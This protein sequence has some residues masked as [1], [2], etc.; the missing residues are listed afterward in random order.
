MDHRYH[1]YAEQLDALKRASRHR[2]FKTIRREGDYIRYHNHQML[3]LSSND[4]LGI[5]QNQALQQQFLHENSNHTA[6][7]SSS[8]SRLLTGHFEQTEQLEDSLNRAFGRQSLVF[9]SGYHMNIG[10]LPALTAADSLIISDELIHASIIDGIRLSKA[11]RQR[12]AHQDFI[13][14]EQLLI[15]AQQRDDIRHIF[16]VTESLFSMDGDITDLHALVTLRNRYPKVL[17]YVDD[18]HGVGVYGERGLGCAEQH[19]V[20]A[21]IDILVGT[22]GKA[23]ASQGGY[24]ICDGVIR[25]YLINTVRPLI[26]STALP[27]LNLAWTQFVFEYMQGQC[28]AR[29]HLAALSQQLIAAIHARGLQCPSESHIVP[30]IYGDNAHTVA[31]ADQMQQQGYFVLPIRPPTV[32][33]GTSRVRICL[34]AGLRYEQ[35]IPLIACL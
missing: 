11:Q 24:V 6:F 18:A 31:K 35:L 13:A 8:S 26:F 27:P 14:L 3:N 25:D 16:V 15:A 2:Q 33:A 23:L 22:F 32:A 1:Y 34:H 12:F 10:I 30:V 9:N 19:K 21:E 28:A 5:A 17:L 4:Y 7:L 20:I 29:Q